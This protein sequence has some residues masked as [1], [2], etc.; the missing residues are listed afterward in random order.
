MRG[1]NHACHHSLKDWLVA[2]AKDKK[3]T[4]LSLAG[5]KTATPKVRCDGISGSG[6]YLLNYACIS[7]MPL[8]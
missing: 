2:E 1:D 8:A 5:W 6:V 7:Q 3:G 4:V